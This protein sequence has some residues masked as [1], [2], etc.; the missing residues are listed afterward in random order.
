MNFTK[1]AIEYYKAKP[2]QIT[3]L[4]NQEYMELTG[5]ISE[6]RYEEFARIHNTTLERLKALEQ[7]I[8]DNILNHER[9]GIP[10]SAQH[11]QLVHELADFPNFELKPEEIK[12]KIKQFE[13]DGAYYAEKVIDE[14]LQTLL[15]VSVIS[16]IPFPEEPLDLK[17]VEKNRYSKQKPHRCFVNTYRHGLPKAIREL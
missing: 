7:Q 17:M 8:Q 13:K 3:E 11:M 12:Q 2:G 4:T 1:S 6:L 14:A 9:F 10:L 5:F 16:Q 15:G